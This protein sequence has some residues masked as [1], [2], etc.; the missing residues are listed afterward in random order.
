MCMF[1]RI[2]EKHVPRANSLPFIY[3]TCNKSS[4][5]IYAKDMKELVLDIKLEAQ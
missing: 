5:Y 4:D 1:S 3:C 2:K